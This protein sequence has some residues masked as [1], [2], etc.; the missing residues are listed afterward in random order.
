M[1][2]G[3]GSDLRRAS[4]LAVSGEFFRVLGVQAFRGRLFEPSDE[5]S[6]CPSRQAVISYA[7]WQ[8][9][10]GGRELGRDARLTVDLEPQEI[11]GVTP[12]GFFGL[13]VGESFDVALP[14]C[15]PENAAP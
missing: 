11:I 8:R 13:A 1:R 15:K 6:S 7:Y 9:E 10:L 4:G 2:V 5:A 3:E 12:P 14:F